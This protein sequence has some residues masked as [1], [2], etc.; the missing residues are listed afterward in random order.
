MKWA[1]SDYLLPMRC[2]SRLDHVVNPSE[3]DQPSTCIHSMFLIVLTNNTI[4]NLTLLHIT[5][6]P[7]IS[8]YK[9]WSAWRRRSPT[10]LFS[11]QSPPAIQTGKG[12]NAA[13]PTPT[14]RDNMGGLVHESSIH[15]PLWS[16]SCD[17]FVI[18]RE[19]ANP[20][21]LKRP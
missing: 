12:P 9:S 20:G 17:N 11:P 5:T 14:L 7:L 10:A 13:K 18:F 21:A 6:N 2:R 3:Q 19:A 15:L 16:C 4:N 8:S 1:A